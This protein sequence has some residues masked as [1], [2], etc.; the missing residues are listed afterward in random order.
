MDVGGDKY[1]HPPALLAFCLL[2][3]HCCPGPAAALAE[4]LVR[5]ALSAVLSK[6]DRLR[7]ET[8]IKLREFYV[9]CSLLNRSSILRIILC[10][11]YITLL[12][13]L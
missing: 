2:G 10:D 3:P 5:T 8:L 12:S 9:I 6:I 4:Q 11:V 7:K 13:R 1:P